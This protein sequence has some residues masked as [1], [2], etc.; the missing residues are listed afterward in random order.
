[1][2]SYHTDSNEIQELLYQI[3]RSIP[4]H[5]LDD[6]EPNE[7]LTVYLFDLVT[8]DQCTQSIREKEILRLRPDWRHWEFVKQMCTR[9][10]KVY[11]F[12]HK[13]FELILDEEQ[14]GVFYPCSPPS[15]DKNVALMAPQ[16]LTFAA[17]QEIKRLFECFTYVRDL[18]NRISGPPDIELE[19]CHSYKAL[20]DKLVTMISNE[21][22]EADY[23]FEAIE[24]VIIRFA[25]DEC[26]DKWDRYEKHFSRYDEAYKKFDFCSACYRLRGLL[27]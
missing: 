22:K 11:L 14:K 15:L 5:S 6:V 19:D 1:M 12:S 10:N 20:C 17:Q 18:Y 4:I 16:P 3:D 7:Y 9:Y 26:R 13:W 2:T 25:C 23:W 27:A 21:E 8:L 24:D